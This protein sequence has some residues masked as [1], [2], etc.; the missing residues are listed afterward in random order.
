[1]FSAQ[2]YLDRRNVLKQTVPDGLILLP[3]LDDSPMNFPDNPYTFRQDSTFLYYFGLDRPQLTALIDLDENRDIIFGRDW[4]VE[5][6]VWRG[7]QPP[8]SEL[9][10]QVGVLKTDSPENLIPLLEDA[11]RRGRSVHLLPWYRPQTRLQLAHFLNTPLAALNELVSVPLIK[12]VVAQRSVKDPG[13]VDQ[14]EAALEIIR[15][16]HLLAMRCAR[17]GIYE[18][19]IVGA[20]EGLVCARGSS[21]AFPPILTVR[22]E[23]LHNHDHHHPLRPGDLVLN[24]SGA[25]SPLHYA[26]DITRTFPAAGAFSP[27]QKDIYQIV[28]HALQKAVDMLRPG[29][30]FREVHF[31][32]C[33][34]LV[35]GLQELGLMTGDPDE[36]VRAGAH[37]LFF[38]CGLGHMLGLDV[39]DMEALGED[40]V[41]YSET[42]RRRPEFGWRSLRL[43]RALEPGFVITVEPGLYFIPELIDQWKAD[44]RH[45]AFIRYP[46]VEKFRDFGGVRIE[47][48]FL[49]T[50]TAPRNLCPRLPKTIDQVEAACAD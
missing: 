4:T 48:D 42:V 44:S 37:A 39:H 13:E 14:I 50:E 32:A 46:Q 2:T 10:Q 35:T 45:A 38:P 17:P 40:Y 25:Q 49:V 15:D 36:A 23:I 16:M 6:L 43:A 11:R 1:M 29:V 22:G 7:R 9:A 30:E 21:M 27:R 3:G 26:G 18:R 8:L 41:G 31:Q 28:L 12:A 20:M 5:D 24:D 47:D 34:C 19:E 33:R